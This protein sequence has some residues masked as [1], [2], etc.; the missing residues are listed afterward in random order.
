MILWDLRTGGRLRI[1]QVAGLALALAGLVGLVLPGLTA[2][3]L[4]GSMLMT[5]SGIAWGV[6]SLRGRGAK[7]PRQSPRETS[8]ARFPSRS[9]SAS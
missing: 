9:R 1:V 6:Y 5:L 4:L 7:D 8:R 3:P 2:P